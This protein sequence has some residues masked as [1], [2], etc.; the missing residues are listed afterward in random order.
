MFCISIIFLKY[1]GEGGRNFPVWRGANLLALGDGGGDKLAGQLSTEHMIAGHLLFELM[2]REAFSFASRSSG[3]GSKR[4]R[5][6][7]QKENS[8]S[9]ARSNICYRA[10]N[11]QSIYSLNM[12]RL[13]KIVASV[14]EWPD[15]RRLGRA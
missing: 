13:K 14:T 1:S 4:T 7:I 5:F 11:K 10:E 6:P 8:P 15:F 12:P 9:P 3:S 2:P